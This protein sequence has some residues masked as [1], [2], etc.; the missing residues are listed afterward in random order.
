[1][2]EPEGVLPSILW[3]LVEKQSV[4]LCTI[5]WTGVLLLP[6]INLWS[7]LLTEDEGGTEALTVPSYS[8]FSSVESECLINAGIQSFRLNSFIG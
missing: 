7:I 4:E 2:G 6:N 8:H 1:M 3:E 5:H